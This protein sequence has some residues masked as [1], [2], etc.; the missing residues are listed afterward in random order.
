VTHWKS[1]GP[2]NTRWF[3][4]DAD[5]FATAFITTT[6]GQRCVQ[7]VSSI[8]NLS[9]RDNR[10]PDTIVILDFNPWHVKLAD[11]N[12]TIYGMSDHVLVGKESSRDD[13]GMDATHD[14]GENIC[15]A[16]GAFEEDIECRLP[17]VACKV[18]GKW[19]YDAVLLDE[20][21]ILGVRV[22]LRFP[23]RRRQITEKLKTDGR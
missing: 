1:W 21:R 5:G 20:E 14:L 22:C 23:Y 11:Y 17:F 15:F 2:S 13:S 3:N 4:A 7:F 8:G 9:D 19:S 6:A 12:R 16:H 18:L 10:M